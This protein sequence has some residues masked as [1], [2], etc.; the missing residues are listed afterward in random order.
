MNEA[1]ATSDNLGYRLK[2]AREYCG[3]SQEEVARHL[4][5]PRSAISLMENGS[6]QVRAL[7]LRSLATL[8][9]TTME[10]LTGHSHGETYAESV[11]LVARAAADLSAADRDEV[12][13]FAQF[14]RTRRSNEQT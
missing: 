13:R 4:G 1:H 11:R 12:L 3:F 6:R 9:Q 5:V 2:E 8:Y 10:D 14:L 7:E